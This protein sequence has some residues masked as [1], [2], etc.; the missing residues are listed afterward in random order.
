MSCTFRRRLASLATVLLAVTGWLHAASAPAAQALS[1]HVAVSVLGKDE[2]PVRG[3][4]ARDFVVREDG[5]T[6]EV[7]SV[8]PGGAPSH[9]VLLVDDSQA[10]TDFLSYLRD[11]LQA[12][13]GALLA[14]TPAPSIRLTTVGDRPTV[15]V[16]F[17]TT[18]GTIARG[19]S[20]VFP[21]PAAG[22]RL[23]EAI[24][25]TCRDLRTRHIT[26]AAIVAFVS[27]A[28]PEFSEDSHAQV[29]DAL[30]AAGATL[31]A[32]VVRDPRGEDG[33]PEG[34]ERSMVLGDVTRDSGGMTKQVLGRQGIA[35]AFAA[36]AA[37]LT[38][39]YDVAYGRPDRLIPPT[40]VEVEVS[41]RDA[42][43]LVRRWAAE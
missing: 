11:G 36:M 42:Q 39:Q 29:A 10:S 19:V 15:R 32:I 27:E 33:S 2:V 40:R 13:T 16:D 6:R 17:S 23:L 3:L 5:A 4:T 12:F 8:T 22:S 24:T 20:T 14:H 30:K 28:G 21:K 7:I 35:P 31:S 18:A 38:S 43:V 34:R 41:G 37:I 25:E 26:G 1:R 9:V